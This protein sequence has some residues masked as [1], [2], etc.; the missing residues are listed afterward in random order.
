MEMISVLFIPVMI[1]MILLGGMIKKVDIYQLFVE[2]AKDGLLSAASIMPNIIA[3]FLA[4]DILSASGGIEVLMRML[5]PVFQLLGIPEGLFPLIL[6]RPVSGSGALVI[7]EKTVRDFGADSFVADAAC[8]LMGS[9]ETILYTFAV[10]FA[11]TSVK[12]GRHTM[13]AGMISY[14]AGIAATIMI[15]S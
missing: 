13:A 14:A 5:A 3:I 10:Y 12:K 6:M 15:L 9:S 4:I 2:G 1:T 11:V 7:V 8:V